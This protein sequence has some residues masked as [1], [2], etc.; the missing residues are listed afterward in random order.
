MNKLFV[1]GIKASDGHPSYFSDGIGDPARTPYLESA[2]VF[3]S[4]VA[5]NNNLAK[6]KKQF[7]NKQ[8]WVES[9]AIPERQKV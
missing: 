5:A 3:T 4:V 2:K 8:F 6:L 1:I 7:T 9:V